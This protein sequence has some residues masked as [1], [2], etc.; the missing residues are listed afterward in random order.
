MSNPL[1]GNLNSTLLLGFVATDGEGAETT[2][3]APV[4]RLLGIHQ[5]GGRMNFHFEPLGKYSFAADKVVLTITDAHAKNVWR[6][7]SNM[8]QSDNVGDNIVW[9]HHEL[10][11]LPEVTAISIQVAAE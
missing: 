6:I 7:L 9:L 8:L 10:H 4:S 3:I 5:T 11:G 2:Y 1:K